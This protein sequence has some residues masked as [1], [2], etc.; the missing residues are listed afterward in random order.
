MRRAALPRALLLPYAPARR[1]LDGAG[2]PSTDYSYS[3][4]GSYLDIHADPTTPSPAIANEALGRP[5]RPA[6]R[7]QGRRPG[8]RRRRLPRRRAP[9]AGPPGLLLP[10]LRRAVAGEGELNLFRWSDR[11]AEELRGARHGE[12]ECAALRRRRR[13]RRAHFGAVDEIFV[14]FDGFT[15]LQIGLLFDDITWPAD[16]RAELG[17]HRADSPPAAVAEARRRCRCRRSPSISPACRRRTSTRTTSWPT[18]R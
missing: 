12:Q 6:R 1:R 17:A 7:D 15:A 18:T 9:R 14:Y 2:G 11:V 16:G 3:Y 4:S 8:D 5:L 10:D 13:W